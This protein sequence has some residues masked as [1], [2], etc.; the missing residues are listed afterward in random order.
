KRQTKGDKAKKLGLEPL[1]RMIMS[2][3]GGDTEQMAERFVKGEVIDEDMA[4]QGA[5]DIMA[6]W[7]DDNAIARGRVRTL[8]QRKA[9]LTSKVVKGKEEEGAKYKDYF[10]FSEPLYRIASHR[11]LAIT[12][13]EREGILSLKAQ[14][15]KDEALES[16]ERF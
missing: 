3:R 7:I 11:F 9:I 5:I 2:Q 13:A 14:P 8:F 1:A 10:E 16:L 15:D 6:E 12:R 4:I